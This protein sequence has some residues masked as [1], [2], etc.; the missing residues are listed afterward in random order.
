MNISYISFAHTQLK[1]IKLKMLLE[2]KKNLYLIK[3]YINLIK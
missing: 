3:E 1:V 2:L